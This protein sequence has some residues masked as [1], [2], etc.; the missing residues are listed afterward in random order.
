MRRGAVVSGRVRRPTNGLV[1]FSHFLH[2]HTQRGEIRQP[3]TCRL[4]V[5]PSLPI[6]KFTCYSSNF[7]HLPNSVEDIVGDIHDDDLTT[8][9]HFMSNL[10]SPAVTDQF[11]RF[12]NLYVSHRPF[13]QRFLTVSFIFYVL[14]STY[15]GLSARPS[16][17]KS[18][19]KGKGDGNEGQQT[20]KPARVAV[21]SISWHTPSCHL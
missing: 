19:Q 20:G 2:S 9:D 17:S 21:R 1:Y 8:T 4:R 13:V 7:D 5:N 15:R 11:R 14:G 12:S 16:T 10:R 18:K 6:R 3:I